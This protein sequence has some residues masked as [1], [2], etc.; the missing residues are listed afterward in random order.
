MSAHTYDLRAFYKCH[1][2]SFIDIDK[3]AVTIHL[4]CYTSWLFINSLPVILLLLSTFLRVPSCPPLRW[5]RPKPV[6]IV[7]LSHQLE[8]V[9]VSKE[10]KCLHLFHKVTTST[11][12]G[13][14]N[15]LSLSASLTATKMLPF[16]F[17]FKLMRLFLSLSL[18]PLSHSLLFTGWWKMFHKF[19]V[20]LLMKYLS[21]FWFIMNAMNRH[22]VTYIYFISF[23][24]Y[25]TFTIIRS[26]PLLKVWMNKLYICMNYMINYHQRHST[27][28]CRRRFHLIY[29]P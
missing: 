28:S 1:A 25:L 13:W 29:S 26:I 7:L 2:F 18:S 4:F 17:P 21:F 12:L 14:I 11:E 20:Q 23:F 6:V 10:R 24:L 16:N 9:G 27:D 3:P 22:H 8:E 15:Q 19:N 5:P